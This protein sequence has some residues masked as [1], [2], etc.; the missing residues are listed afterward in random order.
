ML[1]GVDEKTYSSFESRVAM[2]LEDLDWRNF[3]DCRV[4][5]YDDDGVGTVYV[6]DSDKEPVSPLAKIRTSTPASSTISRTNSTISVTN[7]RNCNPL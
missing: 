4:L 2:K 3:I 5:E 1:E 7:S 6:T